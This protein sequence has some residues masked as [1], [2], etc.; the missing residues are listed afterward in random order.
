MSGIF[1]LMINDSR[2]ASVDT[3]IRGMR[4][5]NLAYG[6]EGE[7]V[8]NGEAVVL[9]CCLEKL[10]D[11][12]VCSTPVF[13]GEDGYAVVD[14]LLYNHDELAKKCGINGDISD[15][16]LL[17]KTV[18][19]YGM[20]SLKEINGDFSGALYDGRRRTLTLFRDHMG[21]RPLFYYASDDFVAFSTDIRGLIALK[22][23][24]ASINEE[25][26]YRAVA[27][28]STI[29]RTNTEYKNIFCVKPGSYMTF[30]FDN[31]VKKE[32]NVYWEPGS[33]KIKFKTFD[34]YKNK[35]R[36]LVTDSIKR[37]LDAVSGT[38]G[39]ELSG[40]L[41]SGVI[42]I[43]IHR[44]GRECLYFSWSA[45][46]AEVSYAER[47]ERLIIEDICRQEGITCHYSKLKPDY[48]L[49]SNIAQNM[50]ELGIPVEDDGHPALRYAL[51]PY[52]NTL[53]ICGTS[54]CMRKNGVRVVF[55]GHGGDEGVSHRSRPYELF[56]NHEYYHFARQLWSL[57]HGQ[58]HRI[59]KT[60]KSMYNELIKEREK[61]LKP[62]HMPFGVP[63]L[64][65]KSFAGQFKE[66]DMPRLSFSYSPIE[67]IKAGGSGNRLDNVALQGAY[68]GVRYVVPYLDYRVIDFAVSVPRH[69]YLKGRK[70]RYL[71]RE[72]FRDIMP[73]S[74]YILRDKQENST[75]NIPPDL[76]WPDKFEKMKKE[77]AGKLDR[78]VWERY[79][80]F[81]VIDEWLEKGKPS[82]DGNGQ[83]D[84]ILICIGYCAMAQNV[85]DKAR[86]SNM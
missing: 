51:P 18:S 38:V 75:N 85:I 54:E 39:A 72:A 20:N 30:S 77:F 78:K 50:R 36:E 6:R 60:L 12:A 17:L 49:E 71:F 33:K 53:P 23:V 4:L 24:D 35:L 64:L 28:Y 32:E 44:L 21:V 83:D 43:L 2:K 9:G 70:N 86:S 10:S 79:L 68:N 84:N 58:K 69:L 55:T 45:D 16:E 47:D 82:D 25:W 19:N 1:G 31:G 42:D 61:L 46:V 8:L 65:N 11:K 29:S 56:Y 7:E 5:W 37:R 52:I 34:E 40:G 13:K 15:E 48:G 41:D 3:D 59:T 81:G 76:E 66:K 26:V 74:L 67:Y 80:D 57:T 27:G 14:A 63:E 62:F 22:G 73:K